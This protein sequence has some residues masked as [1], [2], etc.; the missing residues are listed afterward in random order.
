MVKASRSVIPSETCL[1][2]VLRMYDSACG[3]S[4]QNPARGGLVQA[5]Q[6]SGVRVSLP[7]PVTAGGARFPARGT[8]AGSRREEGRPGGGQARISGR[9][10]GGGGAGRGRTRESGPPSCLASRQVGAETRRP[11]TQGGGPRR[12]GGRGR[13]AFESHWRTRSHEADK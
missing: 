1:A 12:N 13:A 10:L 7:G 3:R 5:G 6:G 2:S 9:D 4:W 11:G 8:C